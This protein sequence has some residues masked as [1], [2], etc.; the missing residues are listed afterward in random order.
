MLLVALISFTPSFLYTINATDIL[1]MFTD[2]ENIVDVSA[3]ALRVAA[4]GNFIDA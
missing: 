1:F 3:M 2:N 4:V